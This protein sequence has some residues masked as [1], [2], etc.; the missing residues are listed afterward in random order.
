MRV[1]L[2]TL[3][4][5][6]DVEPCATIGRELQRRG[7]DV[8]MAVPPNYVGFVESAGLAAV[9]HGPDQVRQN[10]DIAR[11]YGESPNPVFMAWVISEDLKRLWP[12]LGTALTSLADGAD[13]LL[14]D[15]S[16]Q[17]LAANVAEYYD[18]PQAAL[19]IYPLGRDTGTQVTKEA[20]DALRQTLGLP[21]QTGPS[22]RQPLEMQ[23]YDELF[24][25]G[26][27]AEWAKWGVR[28]PFVGGLTL[29]LTTNVDDEVSSWIAA[30]TP[31]IYFGFGS[32]A[33]VAFHAGL[34]EMING[35]CAQLGERA[36][37]CS[38]VSDLA[39]IP[40]FDQVKVVGA[41][42][43]SAV[44]PACRAVVH[45]GGPGT[46]F[47]GIRAGKPTLALAVSVDQPMWAAAVGQLGVGIGRHFS[48]TTPDSLL[49][50]LR[51]ILTPHC[52]ARTLE[53]AAQMA[54]PAESAATAADLVEATVGQDSG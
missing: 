51:A 8:T 21:K 48:A 23:A 37:I 17:G 31:P 18:I 44:F 36:L 22:A 34:L 12:Q 15:A 24:F 26:L 5:R 53:V 52:I 33:R 3:G 7:H 6:G 50:D 1:V 38:G 49:A 11:K 47:A 27:A 41:V 45:H 30:G 13:L 35:A 2:A 9:P 14:T 46:T 19:H 32:S 16:Q 42:N 40:Q 25:P 39:D 29:E 10:A 28:R 54:T 20:E 4:T 43:H